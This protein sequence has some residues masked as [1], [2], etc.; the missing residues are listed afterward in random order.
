MEQE[1]REKEERGGA[2]RVEGKSEF[3]KKSTDKGLICRP[4]HAQPT[5]TQSSMASPLSSSYPAAPSN[6]S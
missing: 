5:P 2:G 3:E 4:R 1:E 6:R